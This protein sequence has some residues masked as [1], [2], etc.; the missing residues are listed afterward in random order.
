MSSPTAPGEGETISPLRT[1][2]NMTANTE[3][4]DLLTSMPALADAVDSVVSDLASL[5]AAQGGDR[6]AFAALYNAHVRAVYWFALKMVGSIAD[7]EDLTQD[8]FVIAWSKRQEIRPV[9]QSVLPWLLVTARNVGNNRLRSRVREDRRRADNDHSDFTDP[10]N[11]SVADEVQGRLL[12]AAIDQA[13]GQLTET[14]QTLYFLCIDEGLSYDQAAHAL[15]TSH[16]AVRNRL[17]R[18]RITLRRK[19][20]AQ[21][22]ALS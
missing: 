8:T 5:T 7:A 2:L 12:L 4:T 1:L 20:S 14:D 15:G 22:E 10:R 11:R 6:K 13:V 17:A 3:P 19:L 9:D 18:V 16:G 21:K